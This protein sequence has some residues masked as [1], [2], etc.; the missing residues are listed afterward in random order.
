MRSI[1]W[2]VL[3]GLFLVT[4]S[5]AHA[6]PKKIA[7]VLGDDIARHSLPIM[8][9][10][11]IQ[12][13]CET[14]FDFLPGRRGILEFNQGKIDGELYRNPIIEQ[15]YD[16]E[17]IRSK[18]PLLTLQQ[19]V[20]LDPEHT[21]YTTVPIGY[22]SGIKW[23]DLYVQN[24]SENPNRFV[25]F[26]EK[27]KLYSAY[28]QGRIKGF[29]SSQLAIRLHSKDFGF[30]RPPKLSVAVGTVNLYHYLAKEHASTMRDI[31]QHI[32]THKPFESLQ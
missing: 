18:Q 30:E 17:F 10:I 6:C 22:I 2:I 1:R 31:D 15:F 14:E 21:D 3:L 12:I 27:T 4:I 20:Y 8:M 7:A 5:T 11:Y 25:R 32:L 13:G 19:G 23:H 28:R 16:H 29:L 26:N 24:K 9:D